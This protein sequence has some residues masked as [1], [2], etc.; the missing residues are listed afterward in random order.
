M[1]RFKDALGV[2]IDAL[3]RYLD[4]RV[5]AVIVRDATGLL[6]V[7][8]PNNAIT[9]ARLEELSKELHSKL[10]GYSP[11]VSR[12]A[13]FHKDLIDRDDILRS[14]DLTRLAP[15]SNIFL[16]DRLLTNQD[17]IRRA[18]R[19]SRSVPTGTAFS[20]KGG[21]GR[22]TGLSVL[23][24]H[25]AKQGRNVLVLDL[26]LEAPGIGNMLLAEFPAR[27]LIDW[28]VESLVDQAGYDLLDDILAISPLSEGLSGSIRVGPAFGRDTE[29]YIPKL[30]RAYTPT[31]IANEPTDFSSRLDSL[32]SIIE[33]SDQKPDAILIDSRAGL[34]DIGAAAVTQIGAE[35]FLFARNDPQTW[36]SYAQ[37]FRHLRQSQNVKWGMPEEDIRWRMKMVAAQIDPS[38][39]AVRKFLDASYTA[40]SEL[41][42]AEEKAGSEAKAQIFELAD[43][44]APHFP[45][46]I[47]F[48]SELRGMAFVDPASRLDWTVAE[49]AF[50]SFLTGATLRL[51]G[52][53]AEASS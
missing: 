19:T 39:G 26:D 45:V 11:G 22:S 38:E 9:E 20:V 1:V 3:Q 40:W 51:F 2:A 36:D 30:G 18:R 24:W 42:D 14:P 25:L 35:V 33:S 16:L 28:F 4:P 15:P 43:E 17:W 41:Y 27:G 23:A 13:L 31:V 7:V 29:D 47:A 53:N 46:R 21:V 52:A 49:A 12:V 5:E 50:G 6:T 44:T 48:G 32:L 10:E 37:L 8:V 34:H